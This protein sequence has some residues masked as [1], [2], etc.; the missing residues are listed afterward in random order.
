MTVQLEA[1]T[2]SSIVQVT[3]ETLTDDRLGLWFDEGEFMSF[4]SHRTPE[5]KS[6]PASEEPVGVK[7][8]SLGSP[9]A[10]VFAP[11]GSYVAILRVGEAVI[12]TE[13]E[14]LELEATGDYSVV[15][16]EATGD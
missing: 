16:L 7:F 10:T 14:A 11:I 2:F 12:L 15:K 6:G 8:F 9:G 5:N 3:A 13:A 4:H 1:K